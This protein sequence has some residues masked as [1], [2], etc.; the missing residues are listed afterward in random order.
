MLVAFEL[1]LVKSGDAANESHA[2]ARDDAFFHRRTGCVHGVL[3][4]SLL[5]FHFRL[6][7][8]ANSDNGYST[9]QFRQPLLQLLAVVV[10]GG[11]TDLDAN[12]LHPAFDVGVL[13]F[14]FDEGGVLLVNGDLLGLSEIL[15]LHVLEL[16]AKIFG[17]RLPAGER[18]NVLQ[19]GLA[20]I[21]ESRRLYRSNLQGPTQLVDNKSRK[22]LSLDVLCDD[23]Q[24]L[25]TLGDLLK[26]RE[27]VLHGADLPFVDEDTGVLEGN[28][29]AFR[30]RD[31]VR[32]EVAA[33][34]LHPLHDLELGLKRLRL[35]DSDDAILADL[36]HCFRDDVADGVVIVRGDA[37]NLGDH[38]AGDGFG[39]LIEFAP[40]SVAGLRVDCAANHSDGFLDAAFHRHRIGSGS[41]GLN[42]FAINGL[43]QNGS[44]GGPVAGDVAGLGGDFTYHLCAHVLEAILQL[45]LFR[46]RDAVLGYERRTELL[47]NHNVA[48]LGAEGHL[49]GVCHK[50]DAAEDRLPRPFSLND[51]LCHDC[52]LLSS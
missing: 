17:D 7:R 18:C 44:R 34:E 12:F 33:V 51:L 31:E 21:A 48:A 32:R 39:Q 42:A 9:D 35:F 4:S 52:S 6:G 15:H 2:A 50:V 27:D 29:H 19:H 5:L 10:A 26:Q 41:N 49:H 22:G 16:D 38:V 1:Q 3:D 47:L 45:D 25:A 36:L 30:I 40:G 43:S 14:A 28:F 24:R 11:L 20:A 23:K 46:Y 37:A 13:G 8:R